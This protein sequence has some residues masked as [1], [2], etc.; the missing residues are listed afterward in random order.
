MELGLGL[1]LNGN[2]TGSGRAVPSN[3]LTSK[4]KVPLTT[5]DGLFLTSRPA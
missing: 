5:K 3:V 2:G 1:N 4:A